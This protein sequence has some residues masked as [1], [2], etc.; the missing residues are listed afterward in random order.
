MSYHHFS[1]VRFF[2]PIKKTSNSCF[3]N[4][5]VPQPRL[6]TTQAANTNASTINGQVVSV[7]GVKTTSGIS[8]SLNTTSSASKPEIVKIGG[9]TAV[10]SKPTLIQSQQQIGNAAAPKIVQA[11]LQPITAQ[12]LV[13]AKV[14]GV[15]GFQQGI[16]PVTPVQQRVKTGTASIRMVNASN[17]N[18]ANIDGKPIIIA[19]TPTMIQSS[20]NQAAANKTIWTQQGGTIAK[21]NIIGTLPAAQPTSQQVVFGNQIVKIQPQQTATAIQS[22]ASTPSASMSIASPVPTKTAVLLSSTGQTI[23]VQPPNVITTTNAA[24]KVTKPLFSLEISDLNNIY[25]R[26]YYYIFQNVIKGTNLAT[27]PGQ[28]VVLAVQGGNQF[29]LPQNFQ[30]GTINWKSLQGL[31]MIPIQTHQSANQNPTNSS[32]I[33]FLVFFP[34]KQHNFQNCVCFLNLL[35]NNFCISILIFRFTNL[36]DVSNY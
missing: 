18:I 10:I 8:S 6:I 5:L 17:L 24:N 14:L 4:F 9:K 36:I 21:A 16:S 7:S 29:I 33:S 19:K 25:D 35:Y 1:N 3:C 32:M 15:Q 27:S 23:K 12:Q 31:K 13:N 30:G 20:P 22:N 28:R 11:Q 34:S 26:F 2:I